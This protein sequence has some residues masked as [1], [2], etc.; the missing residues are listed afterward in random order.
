M[1]PV[2]PSRGAAQARITAGKRCRSSHCQRP[3]AGCARPAQRLAQAERCS[4]FVRHRP[5]CA[6][7]VSTR[8]PAGLRRTRGRCRFA[9]GLEQPLRRQ[10]G[11][12]GQPFGRSSR[13]AGPKATALRFDPRPNTAGVRPAS[14]GIRRPHG[15][16]RKALADWTWLSRRLS[17]RSPGVAAR[18]IQAGR[19]A[20]DRS[21]SVCRSNS[22]ARSAKNSSRV[23]DRR[24]EGEVVPRDL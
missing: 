19:R 2:R 18:S 11:G 12:R 1:C 13:G 23:S 22:A 5:P 3:L 10:V 14:K 4:E 15:I 21:V 17:D 8:G 16:G 7:P 6:G 24:R 9:I 20:G